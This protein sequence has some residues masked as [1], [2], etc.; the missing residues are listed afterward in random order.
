MNHPPS[1]RPKGAHLLHQ[2]AQHVGEDFSIGFGGS[3]LRTSEQGGGIAVELGIASKQG[4]TFATLG[5][6][7]SAPIPGIGAVTIHD[8]Y[9]SP[10]GSQVAAVIIIDESER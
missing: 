10:D 8:I 2:A 9:V 1:E 7:E 4:R 6:G 5:V 3:V